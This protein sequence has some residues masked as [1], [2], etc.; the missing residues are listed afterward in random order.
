MPSPDFQISCP[1]YYCKVELIRIIQNC[2][3]SICLLKVLLFYICEGGGTSEH[4][5]DKPSC[6]LE[7][8]TLT[9]KDYT[10]LLWTT[11]AEFPGERHMFFPCLLF[12]PHQQKLKRDIGILCCVCPSFCPSVPSK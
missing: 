7:C 8:K 12:I 6:S 1:I 3:F 2:L 10:D 11:F 9:T 4:I 5:G